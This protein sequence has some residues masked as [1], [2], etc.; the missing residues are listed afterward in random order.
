MQQIQIT[1]PAFDEGGTI[2]VKYSCDGENI[3]PPLE[4][5][6]VPKEAQSLALIVDD[7]DAPI[8][9]Y[10]HWV[11]YNMEAGL[12]NLPEGVAIYAPVEYQ[13]T[14]AIGVEG[15][16]GSG[17]EGY[18]GPCPPGGNP[19]RYYFKLYALDTPLD[20]PAGATKKQLES[21]MQGKILAQGQLMGK[22]SRSR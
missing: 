20:L 14:G 22:Y 12:T 21:A 6:G 1:S 18:R 4:W 9:T 11:V 2:P 17:N 10:V 8:G 15:K 3:S 16:N 7:P 13:D 5:S 19:H